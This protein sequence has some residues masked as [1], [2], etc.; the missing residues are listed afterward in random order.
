MSNDRMA[1]LSREEKARL[2]EKL[3]ARGGAPR[4]AVADAPTAGEE[5]K[6][7]A[8]AGGGGPAATASI[9]PLPPDFGPPPLSF[10]QGRLWLVD[11]LN[12]GDPTYHIPTALRIRGRFVPA[13]MAA[14]LGGVVARHEALRTTFPHTESGP[15]QKVEPP[16]PV[17]L[18]RIDLSACPEPAREEELVRLFVAEAARPFSLARGPLLR[19]L[20]VALASE[21][22]ALLLNLHHIISDGW[23]SSILVAE[24]TALYAS[25]VGEGGA[26][27]GLPPLPI[28]Y[29]D[30]AV[31]Q[32]RYLT[33]AELERQLGYW[34][35]ALAGA[36]PELPLPHDFERPGAPSGRGRALPFELAP[37]TCEAVR[38]LARAEGSTPYMVLLA[39]WGLFLGGIAKV[40]DLVIGTSIANRNRT[41]TAGLI[42]LF[43]NL[44]PLRLVLGA[45]GGG[46]AN[47]SGPSFRELVRRARR[48]SLGAF[49]H[50][51]LPF[52]RLV[53]EVKVPRRLGLSPVF[54]VLFV[55]INTP[56]SRLEAAGL[57]FA[58]VELPTVA[59]KFDLSLGFVDQ[60]GRYTAT[61]D[62]ATDLFAPATAVAW[63]RELMD[64]IGAAV[65]APDRPIWELSLRGGFSRTKDSSV[66]AQAAEARILT[67]EEAPPFV[68][69]ASD[70]ERKVARI[71]AELLGAD[72]ARIGRHSSFFDL[73]GHSLLAVQLALLIERELKV[74]ISLRALF[75]GPTLAAFAESL[76]IGDEAPRT[77]EIQEGARAQKISDAAVSSRS[78]PRLSPRPD[79]LPLSFAQSRLWVL[80]RLGMGVGVGDSSAEGPDGG[81]D[82]TYHIPTSLRIRGRFSPAAMK[83]ALCAVVARHEAL[84]TTFLPT[85]EGPVQRISPP[86]PVALPLIDLAACRPA[87][88]EAE[89]LRILLAESARPF[90]LLRGPLLRSLAVLLG[91]EDQALLLN[92]HH[93]VSDA[94]SSAI[95]V[96]ESAAC[97][98][99]A[100][101]GRPVELPPLPIQYPDFAVWQ[102]AFL[103]G[104][105]LE[106][107]LAFWR[108]SLAGAPPE[109]PLPLD[110][111]RPRVQ[112]PRGGQAAFEL[113]PEVAEALRSLA[114]TERATPFMILLAG[115]SLFLGRYAG[116][117]DLVVGTP[118]ANR[119]RAEITGLIGFFVN[120]LAIRMRLARLEGE[121]GEPS[122][123]ELIRRARQGALDAFAH[124]DLPFERL[125]EELQPDR[126]LGV[127]PIFQTMFSYLNTPEPKLEAAGLSF[128]QIDLPFAP[129]K[130]DL[131]LGLADRNGRLGGS[132]EYSLD[133]FEPETVERWSDVLA[134]WLGR[135]LA[136]PDRPVRDLAALGEAERRQLLTDWNPGADPR[137]ATG[138][139]LPTLPE[140][141]RRQ[142][143]ST[144]ETIAVRC[145]GDALTFR[146]LDLRTDRLAR[147]LVEL[148]AR[149]EELVGVCLGREIGLVVA[150]LAVLKAGAAYLPLDPAYPPERLAFMLGDGR[151][152]L[153]IGDSERLGRLAAGLSG[154]DSGLPGGLAAFA[155][156]TLV[157]PDNPSE[158]DPPA[159]GT[160]LP[161]PHP[162]SLAYA[163]YT[164]GSTGRPK[165]VAIEH[166][167]AA[168]LLDWARGVFG[169]EERA[170]L[171]A[172]TSVCFDLSV[173]EIFL[174]L[175]CGGTVLLAEN[176]LDLPAVAAWGDVRLVNTVPSAMAELVRQGGI[177]PSVRTVCLAGEALPAEL[178]A[179]IF[180][181]SAVERVWNLYGPS[182]DTTY[183]TAAEFRRPENSREME[184]QAAPPIGRPIAGGRAYLL[185]PP[186]EGAGHGLK[187]DL[188]PAGAVGELYLGGAGVARGYLGRPDLTAERFLPDPFGAVPGARLYRTGDLAR[189]RAVGPEAG[190]LQFLGRRDHQLKV[191]GFRVELG[192]IESALRA[193]RRV[194]DAVVAAHAEATGGGVGRLAAY[195]VPAP[196]AVLGVADLRHLL[197]GRLP[198][199][200]QPSFWVLLDALP[201]SPNGKIDRRALPDPTVAGVSEER[202]ESP[203]GALEKLSAR[204]WSEVLG[205]DPERIGRK[206]SF[207]SLGG[208][209]LL[210]AQLA[211]RIERLLQVPLPL[212][213]LFE[214]PTLE[215][216]ASQIAHFDPQPGR[217][218]KIAR[219]LLRVQAMSGAQKDELRREG[220][221]VGV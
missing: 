184:R 64:L 134:A 52:E 11:R 146:E 55:L 181:T 60:G 190:E 77:V 218:E 46:G 119:N 169:E 109:L 42:G 2:F 54:Q 186:A 115:W 162:S 102:R 173:F 97:Y 177:P 91:T 157:P 59:A 19:A 34:R 73:G 220:G 69:P 70:L 219:A 22:Q 30:F 53:E 27:A 208:H 3:R 93:I 212:R 172:A 180:R 192:E 100:A 47:D 1:G 124:Q 153:L 127:S 101:L 7:P 158:V 80:D 210:G 121:K 58:P 167:Q 10:A 155:A 194:A 15:V 215:G 31:W 174:P 207:F 85:E 163:I 221:P 114:R 106:R 140:T 151:C 36:P 39:A 160:P 183:S 33:G 112:T 188:V 196:G 203:E 87:I 214:H 201:K 171:L 198:E 49:A 110:H 45:G 37:E 118:I 105:E 111:P 21:D 88:R 44:L 213:A 38:D 24:A 107:Q 56:E 117:S 96:G 197:G 35:G 76:P 189:F 154:R 32:R 211:T 179:A 104:P 166:A 175:C 159:A 113:A 89:L 149:P 65:A 120:T 199:A 156:L 16:A 57:G 72:L 216:M 122:F 50:Q 40:E 168:A 139:A 135:A 4:G 164:S 142:A 61:L 84:R 103:S 41:E 92:L 12:P 138:R 133:L 137:E 144:P 161:E 131:S 178:L 6:G 23:S 150:L 66:G 95:L 165:G 17:P 75:E 145:G 187:F 125:V 202:L 147:R 206:S 83:A 25:A 78:I 81:G 128:E 74:E 209:S 62:Y 51:D 108:E 132:I 82:P 170:G 143:A 185:D 176:A 98:A 5:G 193:D 182:E 63:R 13:A 67:P 152:R 9:E 94:W 29:S 20:L 18:P 191:R 136:D 217:A 86:G 116:V 129:P 28:Q 200:F 130:F 43:A 126:N 26:P 99:A 90:S 8:P 141:F 204:L 123:R 14:A 68:P 148:G 79:P 195:V 48:T 205:I 71:W